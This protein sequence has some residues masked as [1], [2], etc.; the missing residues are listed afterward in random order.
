MNNRFL[1]LI[2]AVLIVVGCLHAEA[3]SSDPV[4]DRL[5]ALCAKTDVL[6]GDVAY[7]GEMAASGGPSECLARAILFRHSATEYGEQFRRYFAV[8]RSL[9][10]SLL[11]N[12]DINARVNGVMKEFKGRSSPE[13]MT[14]VYL[15]M[16]GRGY[17]ARKS[18]G[19]ELNLEVMFR[20]SVFASVNGDSQEKVFQFAAEADKK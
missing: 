5:V 14:R 19:T 8:D 2:G 18:D 16:R 15:A 9:P 12:D 4:D 10:A 1:F 13:I 11:E 6:V 17:V 3:P 20:A 7:L